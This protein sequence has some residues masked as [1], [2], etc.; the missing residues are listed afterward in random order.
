MINYCRE[1]QKLVK[2]SSL[3]A[4]CYSLSLL[5]QLNSASSVIECGCGVF[6]NQ[7]FFF[8][9]V[10]ILLIFLVIEFWLVFRQFLRILTPYFS[11]CSNWKLFIMM[12]FVC[13][14]SGIKGSMYLHKQHTKYFDNLYCIFKFCVLL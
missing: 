7:A 13:F 3:V 6:W 12:L 10:Y 4:F 8:S 5:V 9:I 1:K 14:E 11:F 2:D